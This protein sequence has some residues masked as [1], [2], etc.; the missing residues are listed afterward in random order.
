MPKYRH[1]KRYREIANNVV[2]HGFGHLLTQLGMAQFLPSVRRAQES[3]ADILRYSRAQRLRML[4]EELGPTFVKLG[5]L[6]STRSDLIPRD[7]LVELASLQ[8]RV[9]SFPYENVTQIIAQELGQSIEEVF[10]DFKEEP[11]AAASIG[12]VHRAQLHSGEYVVVKVRRPQIIEQMQMDL[13]ILIDIA[14]IADKRTAWGQMYHLADIALELQSSIVEELDYLNEAENADQIRRNFRH[15]DDVIIPK[16]YWQQTTSAVLTMEYVQGVKLNTP[17]ALRSAGHEPAKVVNR[18]VDL[19]YTQ[20]FEHGWFHADPHPGNLAVAADGR[21]IFMD[22]GIVGRLKGERKSQFVLFLLGIVTK[23]PRQ[24]VRSLQN[25]GV[26]SHRVDRKALRRDVER[27][28]D[29]YLDAALRKINL[30]KAVAEIFSLTYQYHIRIPAE[31][32]LLGKTIMTLEGVIE[33]LDAD[34]KLVELLQPYAG[35]LARDRFSYESLKDTATE[36]FFETSDFLI[37]LPRRLND[38]LD[39]LDTEGLPFQINYPDID[40]AFLH[41]D[42]LANRLT[43]SIVLLSFSI[44]MAA[45]IIGA[46]FITAIA[47]ETALL[48]RLPIMEIGFVVATGMATWLIAAIYRS[49]KL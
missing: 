19:M 28:L 10:A 16:I 6:L 20:I 23:N 13:E 33:D 21:L 22:F 4:L 15:R 45:L 8:D 12:Q 40:K 37:S 27:L 5:Q 26:L 32:T 17:D 7:F 1:F 34:L 31:F 42:R 25:M 38:L 18:L 43:F 11:L 3:D 35:R 24:L 29:K 47:G 39:R 48:W 9:P 30:G 44:I 41:L 36:H 46:G 2:R 49:G 14:T